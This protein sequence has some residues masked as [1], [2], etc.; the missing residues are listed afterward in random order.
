MD[1]AQ[2]RVHERAEDAAATVRR[3]DAD[4]RDARTGKLAAGNGELEREGARAAD[5]LAALPSG[6][7]ALDGQ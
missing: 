1:V 6:V 5:D 7:H 2:L 3:V 4:G